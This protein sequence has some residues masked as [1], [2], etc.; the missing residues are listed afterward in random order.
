MVARE[1]S[2]RRQAAGP[3]MPVLTW[4]M[5]G[6]LIGWRSGVRT[7]PP[8]GSEVGDWGDMKEGGT[9]PGGQW[10]W[11]QVCLFGD[12]KF[13]MPVCRGNGGS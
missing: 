4:S 2:R 1:A 7:G 5:V 10:G 13:E 8:G 11:A 12:V 6:L 9:F 3:G